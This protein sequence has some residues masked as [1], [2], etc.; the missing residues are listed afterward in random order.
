MA[1][2][3]NN[4][5]VSDTLSVGPTGKIL[6]KNLGYLITGDD[7][8][9]VV[10]PM[11]TTG[12]V[13]TADTVNGLTWA[14]VPLVDPVL[15][16]DGLVKVLDTISVDTSDTIGADVNGTFVTSPVATLAGLALL[17]TAPGVESAYGVLPIVGG[18]TGANTFTA[19][20]LV[21]VNGAG[22]ALISSSVVDLGTQ[23][24][25][26]VDA[27]PVVIYSLATTSDKAANIKATFIGRS[28]DGTLV[29]S[30]RTEITI[31][32]VA[33][34]VTN[35][36]G[37]VDK[38]SIATPASAAETWNVDITANSPNL[39]FT[40]TGDAVNTVNWALQINSIIEV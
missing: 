32:N 21:A 34:T 11:G 17:S 29:A 3:Y 14:A 9:S 13:L 10:L 39:D 31:N 38:V 7:T 2:V 1:F 24:A 12:Q 27:T 25:Q 36:S 23:T 40:I 22:N 15:A 5:E 35:P 26:T 16:G 19:N 28:A 8:S 30:F 20:T 33:G 18:G 4:I 37:A 6:S